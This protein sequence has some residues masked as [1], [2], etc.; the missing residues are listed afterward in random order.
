LKVQN[1]QVEILDGQPYASLNNYA[2]VKKIIDKYN[3]DPTRLMDIL[4]D[5]RNE[6]G[7]IPHELNQKIANALGI[8][9]ADLEQTLTFYHFFPEKPTG[10]YTVY[11]NNSVVANM[12]GREQVKKTFEDP[13][14]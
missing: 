5:I 10:T 7:Y 13:Q 1:G 3:A 6:K 4:I 9:R 8:S 2:T 12:M 14:Y 11:L